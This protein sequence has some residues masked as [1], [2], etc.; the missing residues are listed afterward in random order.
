MAEYE[1]SGPARNDLTDIFEYIAGDNEPAAVAVVVR[2]LEVFDRLAEQPRMGKSRDELQEGLRSFP[3]GTFMVF[4]RI[5]AGRVVV[6]RV[7]HAA[8]DMDEIFS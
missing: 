3:C 5:W 6:T 2:F 8:R 1:L 4:Y 7:L